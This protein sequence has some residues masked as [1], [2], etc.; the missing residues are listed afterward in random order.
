M[1]AT[2]APFAQQ[3]ADENLKPGWN[4]QGT[5]VGQSTSGIPGE[6]YAEAGVTPATPALTAALQPGAG[7]PFPPGALNNSFIGGENSGS[8]FQSILTDP[9]YSNAGNNLLATSAVAV[10]TA[11]VQNPFGT[12]AV[13]DL[14]VP[15]GTT[16]I[17]VAPF[18][19]TG[20][21]SGTGAPWSVAWANASTPVA[22]TISLTVPP[23][24]FIKAVGAS[25][26]SAAWTPIN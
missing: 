17:L 3:T 20:V 21:P 7:V 4:V 12:A 15:V 26:T 5:G 2:P 13:V 25:A 8:Y 23:A 22:A 19:V 16:E 18:D 6:G 10:T 1:T 11:G 14:A 9:G 24:G